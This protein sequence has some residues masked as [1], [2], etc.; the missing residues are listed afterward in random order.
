M[1]CRAARKE[2]RLK[3]RNKRNVLPERLGGAG[4]ESVGLCGS[5]LFMS[6]KV[7][8]GSGAKEFSD[9]TYNDHCD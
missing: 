3:V 2:V 8:G 1:I 5:L 9:L 4:T 7:T 6:W